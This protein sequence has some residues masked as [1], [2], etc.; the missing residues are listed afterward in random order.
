MKLVRITKPEAHDIMNAASVAGGWVCTHNL[1]LGFRS[2]FGALMPQDWDYGKPLTPEQFVKDL[3][4]MWVN[5]EE[6]W[7]DVTNVLDTLID[8]EENKRNLEQLS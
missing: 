7:R 1:D 3:E 6:A 2:S 8:H 4:Y 5:N